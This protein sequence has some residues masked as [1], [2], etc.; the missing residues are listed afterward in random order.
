MNIMT[1]MAVCFVQHFAAREECRSWLDRLLVVPVVEGILG[2]C[3]S[4]AE[5]FESGHCTLTKRRAVVRD[6]GRAT[7]TTMY[8]SRI[9]CLPR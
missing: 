3:L 8:D 5:S 4:E 9:T 2:T 7:G 1:T 6:S